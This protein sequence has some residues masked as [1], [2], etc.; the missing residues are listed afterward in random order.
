MF[1]QVEEAIKL[2]ELGFVLV[3]E[4]YLGFFIETV[5]HYGSE[6]DAAF[7]AGLSNKT[8]HLVP[9]IAQANKWLRS[10]GYF[11]SVTTDQ[12]MEPKFCFVVEHFNK[13]TYHW[14][15]HIFNHILYRE[16]E[17]AEYECLKKTI[18]LLSK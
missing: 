17:E 11:G 15:I 16:Y 13:E 14:S 4:I 5:F 2:K 6:K 12:T 3:D 7:L 9:T 1:V 8:Y 10:K 18:N